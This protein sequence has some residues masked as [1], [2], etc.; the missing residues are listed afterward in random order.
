MQFSEIFAKVT[1]KSSLSRRVPFYGIAQNMETDEYLVSLLA[2]DDE[3]KGASCIVVGA[4]SGPIAMIP[5]LPHQLENSPAYD[6]WSQK[7]Y[8]HCLALYTKVLFD[9]LF[10]P[11]DLVRTTLQKDD[12]TFQDIP[13]AE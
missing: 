13:L 5:I 12:G 9:Y 8:A 6:E 11:P 7:E 10:V 4:E 3:N 2:F 1:Y